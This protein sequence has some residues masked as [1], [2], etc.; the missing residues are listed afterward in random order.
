MAKKKPC[1]FCAED[2]MDAQNG[3]NGSQLYLE[4]YPDNNILAMTAYARDEIGEQV[5][6]QYE[7]PLNYCPNCGR[8]LGF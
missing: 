7:L 2:Y 4:I 6:L 8:K 3:P 1:E 5:E